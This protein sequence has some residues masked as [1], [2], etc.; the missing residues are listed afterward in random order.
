MNM[1]PVLF[2]ICLLLANAVQTSVAAVQDKPVVPIA[3]AATSCP[4]LA[5]LQGPQQAQAGFTTAPVITP[6][7]P[8]AHGAAAEPALLASNCL[9]YVIC[10][11]GKCRS[12]TV[13]W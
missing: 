1:K 5:K 4:G 9:T 8:R 3:S 10:A 2:T 6:P 13:C 12:Y 11:G 7:A